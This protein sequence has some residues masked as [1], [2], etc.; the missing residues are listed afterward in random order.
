MVSSGVLD[1]DKGNTLVVVVEMVG[2]E[3]V[4]SRELGGEPKWSRCA[5]DEAREIAGDMNGEFAND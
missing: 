5:L 2:F 4:S 1:G 3:F